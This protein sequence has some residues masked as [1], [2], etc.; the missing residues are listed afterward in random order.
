MTRPMR[1]SCDMRHN[2][3]GQDIHE[4]CAGRS[5]IQHNTDHRRACGDKN[6]LPYV[7]SLP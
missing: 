7:T 6:I 2:R 5:V 3:R 1:Q 4:H